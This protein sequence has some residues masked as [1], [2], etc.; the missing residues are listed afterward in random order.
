MLRRLEHHVLCKLQSKNWG[1]VSLWL[2][3]GIYI[4]MM[5]VCRYLCWLHTDNTA[6]CTVMMQ[7]QVCLDAIN[8]NRA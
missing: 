7:V 4:M 1:N 6:I 2:N 3:K 8:I 5:I